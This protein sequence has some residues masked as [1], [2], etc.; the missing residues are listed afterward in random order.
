LIKLNLVKKQG[1]LYPVYFIGADQSPLA[2]LG[3]SF[4][5]K[6]ITGNRTSVG[7]RFTTLI[8][9]DIFRM[10]ELAMFFKKQ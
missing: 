4:V 2:S 5:A 9:L 7:A 8:S 1:K 10:T 3:L 6:N